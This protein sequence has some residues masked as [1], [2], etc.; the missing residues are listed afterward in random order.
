MMTM[1]ATMMMK[2]NPPKVMLLGGKQYATRLN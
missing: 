1:M 2:V